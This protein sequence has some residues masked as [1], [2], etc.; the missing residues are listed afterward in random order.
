MADRT[1]TP[2]I[3][4]T[5]AV[6]TLTVGAIVAGMYR[7]ALDEHRYHHGALRATSAILGVAGGILAGVAIARAAGIS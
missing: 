5:I 1:M 7:H 4:V 6:T 2:L 3:L